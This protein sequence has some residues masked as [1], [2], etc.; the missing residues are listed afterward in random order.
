MSLNATSLI[1]IDVRNNSAWNQ[2][3]F[4]VQNLKQKDDKLIQKEIKYT[5]EQ[6]LKAVSNE[7]PWSYLRGLWDMEGK[8]GEQTEFLERCK[9]LIQSECPSVPLHV[10]VLEVYEDRLEKGDQNE[11]MLQH[12]KMICD[13]LAE[14]LDTIRKGYW[15]VRKKVFEANGAA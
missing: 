12:G 10:F 8:L 14:K 4:V 2:R 5:T 9:Q 15:T 1:D 6:I 3:F 7:S 13:L 11:E